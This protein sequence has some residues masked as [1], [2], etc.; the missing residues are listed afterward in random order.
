MR[1]DGTAF[2]A[3][4]ALTLERLADVEAAELAEAALAGPLESRAL[5]LVTGHAEGNPFFVEEVLAD[6]LDRGLLERSGD[7]WSLRDA[8]VDLGIPDT[9]RGVLAARIAGR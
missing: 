5:D 9:V 8:A 7:G 2:P 4:E 1:P 3:A 6:L